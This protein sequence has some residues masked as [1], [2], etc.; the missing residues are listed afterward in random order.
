MIWEGD[1][2]LA[3]FVQQASHV[4]V[5]EWEVSRAKAIEENSKAPDIR[6]GAII[7]LSTDNLGCRIMRRT[8]GGF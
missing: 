3:D 7:F 4:V 8:A 1:V 6:F 2:S 5:V